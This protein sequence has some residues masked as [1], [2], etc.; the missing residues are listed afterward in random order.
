[1][2]PPFLMW[3]TFVQ[4]GPGMQEVR[5]YD[6]GCVGWDAGSVTNLR[7]PSPSHK[8]RGQNVSAR[9][10]EGAG[11]P[12]AVSWLRLGYGD[13][14]C[15]GSD[16]MTADFVGWNAISVTNSR[17]PSIPQTSRSMRVGARYGRRRGEPPLFD[18]RSPPAGYGLKYLKSNRMTVGVTPSST[19]VPFVS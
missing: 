17:W 15:G 4:W 11:N 7:R 3:V 10:G 1:M 12:P 9:I 2:D 8:R 14:G 5:H 16:D 19:C 18:L 13:L 6:G